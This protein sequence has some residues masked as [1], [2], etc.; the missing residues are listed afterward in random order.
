MKK[1]KLSTLVILA[2]CPLFSFSQ[3]TVNADMVIYEH[4][5]K[6]ICAGVGETSIIVK[7]KDEKEF[8]KHSSL[9]VAIKNGSDKSVTFNPEEIEAKVIDN[10][11]REEK[12]KAYTAQELIKKE[13]RNIFWFGPNNV[14]S[15]TTNSSITT[16]DKHGN[17]VTT[18]DGKATT[19][20]Y[21]GAKEEAMADAENKIQ[22]SYFQKTTIF[23]GKFKHGEIVLKNRKSKNII[24]TI[25]LG[26]TNFIFDFSKE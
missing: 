22:E 11:G 17:V 7:V 5:Y 21:T 15:V 13:R 6:S 2:L 19:Q 9:V 23:P 26:G 4:G 10:S 3:T 14:S 18:T 25:P 12:C 16:R 1:T 24:L 20:V 8:A